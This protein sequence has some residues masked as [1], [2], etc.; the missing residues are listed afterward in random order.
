MLSSKRGIYGALLSLFVLSLVVV[1]G[2]N[3][4]AAQDQVTLTFWNGFTGPDRPAVEALVQKFNDEHPNIKVE[5]TITPWDS[6]LQNLLTQLSTGQGPDIMGINYSYLPLYAKSG[7][8]SDL[9]DMYAAGAALDPVNFPPAL[10]D[11]MKY[12]GKYYGAPMNFAT[13]LMYY[14]KDLFQAAGITEPAKDWATWIEDIKKL[15]DASKGQYGLAIGEHDTIPN[16]PLFIW[17]N[18]G[19]IVKDGKSALNDPK[20]VEALKTWGEL[21]AKDGVSPYGLSG[22]DADKLFQSGKAAMEITGPWMVNGFIEAKL[23][24]DVAPIPAGPDGAVTY[25]DSVVLMLNSGSA[26]QVEAREFI[27]FW[28][29]KESQ[30]YFSDQTGFPPARTDIAADLK[31]PWSAKFA[32]VADSAR[33]LLPGLDSA[34]EISTDVFLPMIQAITQGQLSAE[35]AAASADQQLADILAQSATPSS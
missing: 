24:F 34:T 23:N 15:T 18:G 31:S 26:H 22:A 8:V 11:L 33:F 14:N 30:A 32:A 25:S 21:V 35:D 20:T 13:L 6:L 2:V 28:N 4:A 7:Y 19:D 29:S 17:G 16:W 12:D 10:V 3:V 5:M 9:S 1:M 27:A